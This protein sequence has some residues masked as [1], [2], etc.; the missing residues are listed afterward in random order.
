MVS[1]MVAC[2]FKIAYL[3]SLRSLVY[4]DNIT[5]TEIQIMARRNVFLFYMYWNFA[6]GAIA[7]S[8]FPGS[9][10]VQKATHKDIENRPPTAH[11][12]F[13]VLSSPI[14]F[15][16]NNIFLFLMT[17]NGIGTRINGYLTWRSALYLTNPT[18]YTLS[19]FPM[20]VITLVDL[21]KQMQ[22]KASSARDNGT[23]ANL[24]HKIS[25]LKDT[26]AYSMVS[27][28]VFAIYMSSVVWANYLFSSNHAGLAIVKA[29]TES[30][31]WVLELGFVFLIQREMK[32]V[33]FT[34]GSLSDILSGQNPSSDSPLTD[35]KK[36][37]NP[38]P[39]AASSRPALGASQPVLLNEAGPADLTKTK[40]IDR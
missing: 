5:D 3:V 13:V 19:Q 28:V 32:K 15:V 21:L 33:S 24:L 14:A 40:I 4:Y 18:T 20:F 25:V 6:Q 30:L 22:H 34:P 31:E 8:V 27:L 9:F 37:S 16:L 35:T 10:L 38:A 17:F 12:A 23:R 26:F 1:F 2:I 11:E 39:S 36:V 7:A 29:I